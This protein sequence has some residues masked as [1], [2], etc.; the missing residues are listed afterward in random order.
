MKVLFVEDDA[1]LL[2]LLTHALRRE[3]YEVLAARDGEVGLRRW[4][5]ERPDIV[6]LDGSLPKIDGFEVCRR[7]RQVARTPIILLTG[8]SSEAEI[9]EGLRS[10]ADDYVTKPF[11]AR[12]LLARMASVLR[13]ARDEASRTADK[14][15]RWGD[16]VFDTE[17]YEL[18][19]G[20]H[21]LGLTRFQFRLLHLLA[22][23]RGHV[24]PYSRLVEYTWG[25]YDASRIPLI[26]SH[27]AQIRKTVGLDRSSRSGQ[28]AIESIPGVGYKLM[29]S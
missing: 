28:V 23:N 26:K 1:E 5:A 12:E 24:V 27:V 18:R 3:G 7:I 22:A 14:F 13:R 19:R 25:D 29:G 16:L 20:E 4:E 10:G 9:V 8:R 11:S 15:L 17:T 2:E 21:I 6:L